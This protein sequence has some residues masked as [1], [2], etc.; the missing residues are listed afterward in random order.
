LVYIF[1]IFGN[2][3][4]GLNKSALEG[5]RRPE[6]LIRKARKLRAFT[7]SSCSKKMSKIFQ[8]KNY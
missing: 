6:Q 7:Y 2:K 3:K 5:F 8:S 1:V 4:N